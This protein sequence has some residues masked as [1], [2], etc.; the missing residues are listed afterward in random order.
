MRVVIVLAVWLSLTPANAETI[1]A[2][3]TDAGFT[4]ALQA[5]LAP[6][7][8]AVVVVHEPPQLE[9]SDLTGGARRLAA[10]A[11][12]TAT[13]ALV[14]GDDGATL[15]AYDLDVDR[16]LVRSLPYHAPLTEAQAAELARTARAM[17]HSLRVTPDIDAPPPHATEAAAIRERAALR[18]PPPPSPLPVANVLAL[19]LVGGAR[20]GTANATAAEHG[21]IAVVWRPDAP[22]L[23]LAGSFVPSRSVETMA[24]SG[25]VSD[26]ALAITGRVPLRIA[27]RWTIAGEGGVAL[28]RIRVAGSVTGA[29]SVES[30]RYDPALRAGGTAVFQLR[31][32]IGIGVGLSVDGLLRRQDYSLD[33]APLLALPVVQLTVGVALTAVIL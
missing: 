7:G 14:F 33:G 8:M 16:V 5:A 15:L 31:H 17:L 10:S 30:L 12:A 18:P 25:S 28:H 26:L 1:V 23:A 22:G 6:A 4:A 29:G 20:L 21:A 3:S 11:T 24:F 19:E 32:D 9:V 27:A 2:A 13:V